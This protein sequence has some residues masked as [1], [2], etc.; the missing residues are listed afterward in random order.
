MDYIMDRLPIAVMW[1]RVGFIFIAGIFNMLSIITT[2]DAK[3]NLLILAIFYAPFLFDLID[4]K[5][6]SELT[7]KVK[8]YGYIIL[9]VC[10]TLTISLGIISAYVNIGNALLNNTFVYILIFISFFIMFVLQ[11]SLTICSVK[12]PEEVEAME[13]ANKY[14]EDARITKKQNEEK[15]KEDRKTDHRSHSKRKSIEKIPKKQKIQGGGL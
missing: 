2:Q 3:V 7:R 13:H 4:K 8:L 11:I 1:F 14:M 10:L 9:G 6:Y 15:I 5:V 12:I